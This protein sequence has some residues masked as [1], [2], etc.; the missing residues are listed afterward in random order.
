MWQVLHKRKNLR[1]TK[2][3]TH[4]PHKHHFYFHRRN[5]KKN[6]FSVFICPFHSI[7]WKL[8][9]KKIKK[10][11]RHTHT[12]TRAH[13][14]SCRSIFRLFLTHTHT[15][16]HTHARARKH[17]RTHIKKTNKMSFVTSILPTSS[18]LMNEKTFAV[19]FRSL[20]TLPFPFFKFFFLFFFNSPS[21]LCTN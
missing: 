20:H 4:F 16:T 21:S 17:A 5:T 11:N 8:K 2:N 3:K 15:H 10:H 14:H 19:A 13:T 7:A 9:Y 12:C 1:I 6:S 18:K